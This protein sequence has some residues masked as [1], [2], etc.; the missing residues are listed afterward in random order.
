M[1]HE[2]HK[3]ALLALAYQ[4]GSGEDLTRDQQ[5]YLAI[6]FYRIATG[7][8]ANAVLDVRPTRGQKLSDVIA[9]RRMSLILHW[10][11]GAMRPDPNTDEQAMTLSEA[12]VAAMDT[13][14]PRAKKAFPGADNREYDAEYLARCWSD[15]AYAHMRSHGRGWFD[16]D[17]PYYELPDVKDPK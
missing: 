6:V 9:R 16:Q 1:S 13:I 17:F 10:V 3:R 14:V 15:P 11:A 12:C 7:E 5:E 8:D 4:I 2:D